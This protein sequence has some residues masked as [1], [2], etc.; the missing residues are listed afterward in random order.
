MAALFKKGFPAQAAS[1]G[2]AV[3]IAMGNDHAF[4]R[5]GK[6][7]LYCFYGIKCNQAGPKLAELPTCP[8]KQRKKFA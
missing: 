4:G 6:Q 7:F 1:H 5:L 3:G 8:M 2:I